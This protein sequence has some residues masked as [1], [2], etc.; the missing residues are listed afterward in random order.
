MGSDRR[1]GRTFE[2]GPVL[3]LRVVVRGERGMC[4]KLQNR[5]SRTLF[6]CDR[7]CRPTSTRRAE[8]RGG[9][10]R[11]A[12]DNHLFVGSELRGPSAIVSERCRPVRVHFPGLGARPFRD[13]TGRL[14]AAPR[15]RIPFRG[16]RGGQRDGA[17]STLSTFRTRRFGG[18][19]APKSISVRQA[20]LNFA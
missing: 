12:S 4:G 3:G 6:K 15:R 17:E 8:G 20:S 9:R 18:A 1:L 14:H 7:V 2:S 10:T 16:S 19:A 5:R 11:G 13:G